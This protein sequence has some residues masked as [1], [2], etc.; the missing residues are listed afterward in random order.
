M[1][2]KKEFKDY[3]DKIKKIHGD[4]YDY[5]KFNYSTLV[6]PS[7]IICPEHGEFTQSLHAH[8][9]GHGCPKCALNSRSKKRRLTTEEFI[10]KARVVHG[11]KYDYSK[12]NY[13]RSKSKVTIICPLHGDFEQRPNDHLNGKG[14][15]KCKTAKVANIKKL[16]KDAFITRARE[17]HSDKYGYSKVEYV[18]NS[19]KVCIICPEHGEFWQR[20]DSHMNGK[21]CGE[22]GKLILG[23][24]RIST[25]EEFITKAI[26]VHGDKYDYSKVEY[27]GCYD[28]VNIICPIHGEFYQRADYH[29]SGNGC[30]KC[31]E[32][33]LER[34]VRLMLEKNEI[35]Y[36]PQKT[37]EWLV[38][39]SNQYLDFFLPD[40]NIAIECQGEQHFK[41]IEYFGGEDA[42]RKRQNLD[43]NKKKLCNENG[44]KLIY[45][46]DIEED[47]LIINS[48]EELKHKI[49][50]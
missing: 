14:C 11:N 45:Y 38:Y 26:E 34:N 43:E 17:V 50:R 41:P 40:Y 23:K 31:S 39:N 20:P 12:T 44:I 27:T 19:T 1:G 24:S 25:T 21:G 4:K 35:K 29:L 28:K 37:F 46:S 32:S 42:F 15:A 8:L 47:N 49:L 5:S 30:P 3:I 7:I 22:C 33:K 16:T 2:K 6:T 9:K 36:E 48:L 18:N 10:T 13:E